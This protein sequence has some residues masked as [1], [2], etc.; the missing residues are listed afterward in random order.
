MRESV[1]LDNKIDFAEVHGRKRRF[2]EGALW[3][4]PL[5]SGWAGV[6]LTHFSPQR[7]ADGQ[8]GPGSPCWKLTLA[9]SLLGFLQ[10]APNLT[11]AEGCGC[12]SI[13]FAVVMA[14]LTGF[15]ECGFYLE[16]GSGLF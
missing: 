16:G 2:P 3:N 10:K 6:G 4:F 12:A 7:V 14:G 8:P 5:A 1:K 13:L 15:S 9:T 11:P